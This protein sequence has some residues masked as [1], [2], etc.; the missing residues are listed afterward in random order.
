L[1]SEAEW[2]YA[3]AGGSQQREY[4]WGETAPGTASQYAIYDCF[5]PAGSAQCAG[6]SL[7]VANIAP[8]G[9]PLLGAGAWGQIDLAG[10]VLE[11][12]MDWYSTFQSPCA[13]CANLTP[14]LIP[15]GGFYR[16]MRGGD[17]GN[18]AAGILST[19]RY[20]SYVTAPAS[21]FASGGA[22]GFRCA[23]TP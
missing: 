13:D 5:Y 15:L 3:A 9:T 17:D 19:A 12:T 11:W 8:V 6:T 22:Y 14:S 4:P 21:R 1:P 20:G 2:E 7:G 16:A 23:R 18:A 10:N